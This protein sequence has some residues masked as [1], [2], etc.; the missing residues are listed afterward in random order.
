MKETPN[1]YCI[2]IFGAMPKYRIIFK[3]SM[4]EIS[5]AIPKLKEE[6]RGRMEVFKMING[7]TQ[8]IEEED[9]LDVNTEI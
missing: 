4:N 6:T 9:Y 8:P 7:D 1:G 3:H 2:L 5:Q